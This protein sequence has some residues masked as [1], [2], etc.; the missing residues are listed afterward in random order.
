MDGGQPR[1][2]LVDASALSRDVMVRRLGAQGYAVEATDDAVAGADM[3]LSN[4]PA[5]VI[6]D[7]WMPNISGI[8]LCRLLK[9]EPATAEVP[10]ILR[11][12]TDDPRCFFWTERSGAAAYVKKGR[13]GELVRVLSKVVQPGAQSDGFFMQLSGGGI[14]IRDRIARYLDVALFESVVAA[15]VRSL[16]ASGSFD[17]LF[18]LFAQFVCQVIGYRWLAVCTSSPARFALHV[19]PGHAELAEREARAVLGIPTQ[20]PALLVVDE[21]AREVSTGPEPIVKPIPFGASTLGKLA[22]APIGQG[23]ADCVSLVQLI[24]RE[25]G[26]PIRIA[27]L[28]DEQQRLAC[29]DPLTGL[30]NRRAFVEQIN[31]EVARAQRYGTGLSLLLLDVDHFKSINDRYGHAGGDRVLSE[32]GELLGRQ[33]RTPDVAARWGGEEFVIALPSTGLDGAHIVAERV[34]A[35]VNSSPVAH[36]EANIRVSVSVGVAALRRGESLE[37]LT[38]RADRAMYVAKQGGRNRVALS[39]DSPPGATPLESKL[40]AEEGIQA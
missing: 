15:E 21:D 22:L 5:A 23:A 30:R 29:V 25:L 26:G 4:P 18:D 32:L 3:A 38:D 19:H 14:D 13:T 9:A 34:R 2:I 37:S 6:A 12:D 28:M 24:A 10:V 16:A 31:V 1:I 27:D 36:E 39:E 17:R 33:L 35:A 20:P 11:G 8:Q 40:K 7:L